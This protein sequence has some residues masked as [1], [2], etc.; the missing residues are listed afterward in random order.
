M[1]IRAQDIPQIPGLSSIKLLTGKNS[2]QVIRW[3]YLV[4]NKELSP[5]LK[6]GELVFVTGINLQRSEQEFCQLIDEAMGESAAGMVI[7]TQSEFIAS[8]PKV[9]LSYASQHHF[10]ILEQPY[11]LPMVEVTELI[12]NA[13]IQDNLMTHSLQHF[14][15][16]IINSSGELSSLS[17]LRASEFGLD[18]NSPVAIAFLQARQTDIIKIDSWLFQLNQWLRLM[19]SPYPTV[20]HHSG[21]YVLISIDAKD[22]T[23]QQRSQW[24]ELSDYLEQFKFEFNI[25]ISAS[26]LGL[27]NLASAAVQA[28]QAAEFTQI[29]GHNRAILHYDDLGISRVFA[30]IEDPKILTTFCIHH[31]GP[32]FNSQSDTLNTLKQTLRCYFDNLG[33]QRQT[34]NELNIHRNTLRN[35]LDKIQQLTGCQ[36]DQAQQ[37]L[38]LQNALLMEPLAVLRQQLS[39][40]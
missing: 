5:W 22:S 37:R 33:C 28:K 16:Q 12:C 39:Q 20:E 38:E 14:I 13:I 36:L 1:P 31:L 4:E 23:E 18:L 24:Q 17:Q 2:Q 32:M 11:S 8:I 35:R 29:H 34:A 3:P 25:G 15:S 19:R 9:V 6:G 10:P 21:W 26:L 7:L 40:G 30:A 27:S